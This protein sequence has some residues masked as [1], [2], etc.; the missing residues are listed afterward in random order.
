MAELKSQQTTTE[1]PDKPAP[2]GDANRIGSSLA[3]R[4]RLPAIPTT[5]AQSAAFP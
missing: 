4:R 2:Q 5:T 1:F 3:P